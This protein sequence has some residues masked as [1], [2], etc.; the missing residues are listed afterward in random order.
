[1]YIFVVIGLNIIG[2]LLIID[3]IRSYVRD[4]LEI[5]ANYDSLTRVHN[6]Y[7]YNVIM[8]REVRRSQRYGSPL[9]LIV[10]DID[11]FKKVNDTLGHKAGDSVLRE[12]TMMLQERIRNSDYLC[13]IGGEE[14]AV[15]AVET[16]LA[17]ARGLAETLRAEIGAHSFSEAGK[18]T[19]SFGV[20][21]LVKDD[22]ADTFFRRA[23]RALYLAKERGRNRVET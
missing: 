5:I 20:A 15:I 22:T 18:V 9:S 12:M 23:D 11:H 4:Q 3:L 8:E 16:H 21:E 10:L 6:R 2:V 13:R 14:F 17:N 7:S 1:G 19:A